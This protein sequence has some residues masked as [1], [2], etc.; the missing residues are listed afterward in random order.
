MKS[1]KFCNHWI[2]EEMNI[3][4]QHNHLKNKALCFVLIAKYITEMNINYNLL[5]PTHLYQCLFLYL[6]MIMSL[7][8]TVNVYF[9]PTLS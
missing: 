2:N 6:L 3:R 9:N 4:E 8:D 1:F 7:C 5:V